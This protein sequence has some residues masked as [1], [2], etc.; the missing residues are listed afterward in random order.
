MLQSVRMLWDFYL[1]N[2]QTA[3]TTI[4]SCIQRLAFEQHQNTCRGDVIVP[5]NATMHVAIQTDLGDVRDRD[6]I[7]ES[8]YLAGV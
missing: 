5:G 3:H 1:G 2:I 7:F 4:K 6:S 8:L